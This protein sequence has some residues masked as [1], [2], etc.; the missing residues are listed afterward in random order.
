MSSSQ[1]YLYISKDSPSPFK[2]HSSS[3]SNLGQLDARVCIGNLCQRTI[4]I[5]WFRSG[6]DDISV[7]PQ[8]VRKQN[9]TSFDVWRLWEAVLVKWGV[10][11]IGL[12]LEPFARIHLD[13]CHAHNQA[14]ALSC[15]TQLGVSGLCEY[16]VH[17][18]LLHSCSRSNLIP[19][20]NFFIL[21]IFSRWLLFTLPP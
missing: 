1:N 6:K 15:N 21:S 10:R 9:K 17:L 16:W 11:V 5:W 4:S 8:E 2:W 14:F 12:D 3:L 19:R 18:V 13:H 20:N 7:C